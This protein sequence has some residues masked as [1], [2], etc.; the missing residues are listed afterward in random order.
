MGACHC[1]PPAVLHITPRGV[2]G[3]DGEPAGLVLV[4]ETWSDGQP[5]CSVCAAP[6]GTTFYRCLPC[7]TVLCRECVAVDTMVIECDCEPEM[8]VTGV[9]LAARRAAAGLSPSPAGGAG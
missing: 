8:M 2:H 5:H 3:C 1:E 4:D 6:I 7:D 9:Q